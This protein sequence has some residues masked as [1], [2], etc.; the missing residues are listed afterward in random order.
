LQHYLKII[1][2]DLITLYDDGITVKTPEYP[3]GMATVLVNDSLSDHL[4]GKRVRV[5]LVLL[6]ITKS[7]RKWADCI[8]P[9]APTSTTYYQEMPEG[10]PYG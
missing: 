4:T 6:A 10:P 8:R 7:N 1:V 2:D 3:D 5:A 9:C